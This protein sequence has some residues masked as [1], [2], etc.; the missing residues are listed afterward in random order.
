MRK[1]TETTIPFLVIE[2]GQQH[3]TS[4]EVGPKGFRKI[5]LRIRDLPEQEIA[6]SRFPARSNE[7]VRVRKTGRGQVLL[8]LGFMNGS[9]R[10]FRIEYRQAG[11][12][13]R[14]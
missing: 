2:Q 7:E 10:F 8:E 12:S 1:T 13:W 4:S 9:R 5:E 3:F 6:D 11:D 14:Q